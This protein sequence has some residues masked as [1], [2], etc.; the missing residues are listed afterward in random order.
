MS[1]QLEKD[2]L[3]AVL[4]E[5]LAPLSQLAFAQRRARSKSASLHKASDVLAKTT[6][7]RKSDP[8]IAI[9]L[10]ITYLGAGRLHNTRSLLAA[11]D[12]SGLNE[13]NKQLHFIALSQLSMASLAGWAQWA[14]PTLGA[15]HDAREALERKMSGRELRA[16]EHELRRLEHELRGLR[17]AACRMTHAWQRMTRTQR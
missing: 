8:P 9:S 13:K 1:V 17:N 7:A 14:L 12:T 11:L 5:M 16:L 6:A 15:A 2:E 10:S 4:R 3:E